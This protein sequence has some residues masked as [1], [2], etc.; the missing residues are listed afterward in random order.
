MG[1]VDGPW[2]EELREILSYDALEFIARL[3]RSFGQRLGSLLQRRQRIQ[4]QLDQGWRPDFPIETTGVRA[5]DW[6]ISPTPT[7]IAD[8]RV[9]ITGPVD[10]KMIINALNSGAQGLHGGF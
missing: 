9:E 8:R 5:A 6:K 1:P 7:E 2:S 10:R 3:E 4:K